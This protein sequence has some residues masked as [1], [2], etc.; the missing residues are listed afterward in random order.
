MSKLVVAEKPSVEP[1]GCVIGFIAGDVRRMCDESVPA[2][3]AYLDC[4][5]PF[6]RIP[7]D[8]PVWL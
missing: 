4:D 2:W 8:D 3:I 7:D 6:A 5:A 1:S